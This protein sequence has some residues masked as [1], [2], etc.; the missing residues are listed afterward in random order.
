MKQ[1]LGQLITLMM[2]KNRAKRL[3]DIMIFIL[4]GLILLMPS[5]IICILIKLTSKG[6][7]LYWSNRVGK[8]N[9]IF[10]MPKFRTMKINTPELATNSLKEPDLHITSC[11]AVLRKYSLDEI[12][13]LITIISGK[14]SFV[15][16]RPALYNQ[17]D[18]I[19]L[20]SEKNIHLLIPGITGYAQINGRDKISIKDKVKLDNY[21]RINFSIYLD[22]KI[23]ILTIKKVILKE[24]IIH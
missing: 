19:K 3:I 13:Q 8:N 22:I 23:L 14:M 7:V 21:Y 11:G 1:L 24:G 6:P 10:R 4:A 18:L 16:P 15:G 20:R 2:K 9:E 12:P 17:F 5:V